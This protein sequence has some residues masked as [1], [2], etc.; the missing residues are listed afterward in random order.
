MAGVPRK[1][2]ISSLLG[3]KEKSLG[4]DAPS[5]D[6]H[7][8]ASTQ[9][10]CGADTSMRS[11]RS[12][13]RIVGTITSAAKVVAR[14]VRPFSVHHGKSILIFFAAVEENS[15]R[16]Q[17][18]NRRGGNPPPETSSGVKHPYRQFSTGQP[19][20]PPAAPPEPEPPVD[21]P[22]PSPQ[23]LHKE[24]DSLDAEIDSLQ[25]PTSSSTPPLTPGASPSGAFFLRSDIKDIPE[26]PYNPLLTPA[27][28]HSPARLPSDQ[29]WRFPSP[30]HPLHSS[31][32][33]LSLS[34]LVHGEASPL[35]SGLDVSPLVI[36]PKSARRKRSMFSSP[37]AAPPDLDRD[38]CSDGE[39][40]D[41]PR[42]AVKPTPRKLIYEGSL[43]TPFTDR[44]KF[45]QHRVPE[46]PL[47]R[48]LFGQKSKNLSAVLH[49]NSTWR[50]P[51]K[52]PLGKGLMDPIQLD[53]DP[54]MLYKP[55]SLHASPSVGT[56]LKLTP[57][58]SSPEMETDSPVLRSS[59]LSSG[60]PI[61]GVGL[62]IG[63]MEG[64]SLKTPSS[65]TKMDDVDEMMFTSD[66]KEGD[67]RMQLADGSPAPL[68]FAGRKNR[69]LIRDLSL[70]ECDS[71]E[72]SQPKKRRRTLSGR[73]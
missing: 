2:R 71:P 69:R 16:E 57:P 1:R 24:S 27:F 38:V 45:G 36:V 9:R 60:K 63:L 26:S 47:G 65:P 68:A 11:I 54:F 12:P 29:P 59:Q 56:P 15:E 37:F 61:S 41:L 31:A 50:T 22:E 73:D 62:G 23:D 43:P 42:R 14:I 20:D 66:G 7:M 39:G 3:Q 48:T 34:M 55:F 40:S 51:A 6:G 30:S 8:P 49:A 25:I 32:Q 33:E 58:S 52:S 46:S 44:I 4:Y 64:F 72:S 70:S 13:C 19:K 35:V 28:R 18:R 10:V 67:L 17:G 5:A 53:E 21:E